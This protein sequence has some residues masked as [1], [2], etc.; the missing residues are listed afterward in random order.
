MEDRLKEAYAW[1]K[2]SAKNMP[3]LAA[4]VFALRGTGYM[5]SGFHWNM[6]KRL[7]AMMMRLNDYD[8]PFDL[9]VHLCCEIGLEKLYRDV[10]LA[11]ASIVERAA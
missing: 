1:R 6:E 10:A 7:G 9:G 4:R 2:R 5:G 11:E 8:S 3:A